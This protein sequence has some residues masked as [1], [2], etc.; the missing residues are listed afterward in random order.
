MYLTECSRA[1]KAYRFN[2][3]TLF[4]EQDTLLNSFFLICF[5]QEANNLLRT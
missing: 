3:V 2:F 4:P 1:P 5:K